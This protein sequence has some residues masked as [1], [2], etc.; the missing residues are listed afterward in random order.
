MVD[1]GTVLDATIT[2]AVVEAGTAELVVETAKLYMAD[3]EMA[4]QPAGALCTKTPLTIESLVPTQNCALALKK[5][6]FVHCKVPFT[7]LKAVDMLLLVS[8]TD[9]FI[10][11]C[12]A[13]TTRGAEAVPLL[14]LMRL[15]LPKSWLF[16]IWNS[17]GLEVLSTK[18]PVVSM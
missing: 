18:R 1:T 17:L 11:A 7:M 4:L 10:P 14:T 9:L 8:L 12:V 6:A 5:A 16:T 3:R 15:P 13:F 2:G